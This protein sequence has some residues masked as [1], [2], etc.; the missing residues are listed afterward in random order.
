MRRS[1]QFRDAVYKH[2]VGNKLITSVEAFDSFWEEH[3]QKL[4]LS[5]RVKRN[6]TRKYLVS[7]VEGCLG[8][9]DF[10]MWSP[11]DGG[12]PECSDRIKMY[13]G[14]RG[15]DESRVAWKEEYRDLATRVIEPRRTTHAWVVYEDVCRSCGILAGSLKKWGAFEEAFTIADECFIRVTLER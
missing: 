7:G 12:K 2:V 13:P 6:N 3:G 10:M 4:W 15:K 9:K 14:G 8:F 11:E 5:L 1:P